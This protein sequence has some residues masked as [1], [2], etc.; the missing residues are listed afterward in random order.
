MFVNSINTIPLSD[1]PSLSQG[2][3]IA[4]MATTQPTYISLG[5]NCDI[6]FAEDRLKELGGELQGL[7]DFPNAPQTKMWFFQNGVKFQGKKY[8]VMMVTMDGRF[9]GTN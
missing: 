3:T 8:H 5:Q 4:T 1:P 6:Y 2:L 9:F 7:Q